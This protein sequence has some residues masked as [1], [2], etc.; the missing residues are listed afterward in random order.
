MNPAKAFLK[1]HPPLW[2]ALRDGYHRLRGRREPELVLLPW[3]V[4]VGRTAI[5]IGAN[6]GAY[7]NALCKL[8]GRVVAIEAN[9]VLASELRR[10]FQGR[11]EVV[12]AAASNLAGE[13][14]LRIPL[15]GSSA[16]GL[17][18][19]ETD[20]LLGGSDVQTVAVP[21]IRI[22]DLDLP[23]VGFIKIDVEGHELAVLE[24]ARTTIK[25]W[26]P[27]LLVEA[28]NR[29]RKDAVQSVAAFLDE[30]GYIGF[31]LADGQTLTS[32]GS[33]DPAVHQAVTSDD[34]ENLDLG[35]TPKGYVSNFV[36][37]PAGDR[38]RGEN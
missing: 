32:L 13:I 4:P 11:A 38:P 26:R 6:A 20:N 10:M 8:G 25:R 27:T 23:D 14:M 34:Y 17:A 30:L 19:V 33:F 22:D 1:L 29:H 2:F 12:N 7:A 28:E 21:A 15:K 3:L 31:M 16:A 18:T 24:G 37:V 5:D 9:P 35:Y 36:F